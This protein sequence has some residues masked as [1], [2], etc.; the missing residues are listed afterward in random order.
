MERFRGESAGGGCLRFGAVLELGGGNGW[1]SLRGFWRGGA[2][3]GMRVPGREYSGDGS[4]VERLRV[5]WG[6]IS[7]DW[8]GSGDVS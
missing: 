1:T 7:G 2:F 8:C 6:W 4:A 5:L 3:V